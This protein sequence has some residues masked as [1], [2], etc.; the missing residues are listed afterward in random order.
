MAIIYYYIETVI[1]PST[2][3]MLD[4]GLSVDLINQNDLPK[5]VWEFNRLTGAYAHE[6]KSNNPNFRI[7]LFSVFSESYKNS[8]LQ[9]CRNN[10]T[11][12]FTNDAIQLKVFDKNMMLSSYLIQFSLYLVRK[13]IIDRFSVKN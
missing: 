11:T 2:T 5:I 12:I 9:K 3:Y 13:K 6:I 1:W 10:E 8:R 7:L 4:G